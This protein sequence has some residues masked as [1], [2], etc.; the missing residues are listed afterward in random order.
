[1]RS[2]GEGRMR[3]FGEGKMRGVEERDG[4]KGLG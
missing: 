2:V 1:M 4:R 3:S